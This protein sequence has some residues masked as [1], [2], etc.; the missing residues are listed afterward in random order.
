M[1]AKLRRGL[2]RWIVETS[3][4]FRFIVVAIA[5]LMMGVGSLQLTKMP[6]DVFPEFAPPRV[7]IQTMCNGLSTGDVESL[8]TVPLEQVFNGIE[9]LEDMR[10][11]SVPQLSSIQLI[12]KP[13]ADL[14][15]ARQLVQGRRA[16]APPSLPT[17]AA[18]PVMLPPLSATSR[19]MK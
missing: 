1:T 14:L 4:R 17:G 9:G 16:P 11:K 18:P 15:H 12:L 7:E 2:M 13:D 3:L 19:V 5:V 10:S 6:V 8:V